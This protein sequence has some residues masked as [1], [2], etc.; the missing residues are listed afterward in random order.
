[1]HRIEPGFMLELSRQGREQVLV[2]EVRSS[3]QPRVARDAIG[4]LSIY[5]KYY[6]DS[7]GVFMAPYVSPKSAD[8]L[9]SEGIGYMDLAGN[10]R[11]EFGDVFIR[12]EG[13]RNPYP[14][15]R[16]IKT[17]FSPKASRIIRVL[18]LDPGKTW[19]MEELSRIAGASIGLADKVKK[20]LLEREW[21]EKDK[22]G[23]RLSTYDEILREW[24]SCYSYRNN[25]VFD[26]YSL[27]EEPAIEKDISRF[28]AKSGIRFALTLFSGA[29]RIAPY[30]RYQ[31]VF[32]YVEERL[33]EITEVL[34]L[35]SAATGPNISLMLPYDSGVFYKSK[36]Y[37]SIAVVS[38]I[39]LFL[40]LKSYKGRGE[41]AAEFLFSEVIEPSWSA[42]ATTEGAR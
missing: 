27:K 19:R 30:T 35:K 17:I 25:D 22:N 18:L 26:F 14:E 39:Q 33:D 13:K 37:D 5:K 24:S 32:A 38:P 7:Y 4:Q 11:L 3:G 23:F 8:L 10:C 2:V 41:E 42:R 34:G 28:C 9:S 15:R 20:V 31:R 12:I 36:K 16:D 6:P 1:M 40:D 21:A 29:S